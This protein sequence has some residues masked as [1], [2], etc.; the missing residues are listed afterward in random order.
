MKGTVCQTYGREGRFSVNHNMGNTRISKRQT[1]NSI[2]DTYPWIEIL[3]KR[4][5]II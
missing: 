2:Q 3:Q 4:C 5:C 1:L